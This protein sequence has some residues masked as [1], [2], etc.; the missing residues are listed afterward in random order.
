MMLTS[1]NR[2]Q[3]QQFFNFQLYK[4]LWQ[5]YFNNIKVT[6]QKMTKMKMYHF[7][8]PFSKAKLKNK[9]T[10]LSMH[11]ILW[12]TEMLL[13]LVSMSLSVLRILISSTVENPDQDLI[14]LNVTFISNFCSYTQSAHTPAKLAILTIFYQLP[15]KLINI[16]NCL[17]IAH[18]QH[19]L[20]KLITQQ[21]EQTNIWLVSCQMLEMSKRKWV[22][23]RKAKFNLP[24][25]Q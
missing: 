18:S 24:R 22:K 25:L 16:L 23:Q 6:D 21:L 14:W 2:P 10:K 12:F 8:I 13:N 11:M 7:L 3:M 17:V 20:S 5:K 1:P 15:P 4:C 19:V 9:S